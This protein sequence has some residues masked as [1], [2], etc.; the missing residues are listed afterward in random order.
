[1]VDTFDPTAEL[2]AK[3]KTVFDA[4]EM[5]GFAK[6]EYGWFNN[7]N[8]LFVLLEEELLNG[9]P[10]DELFQGVE[11][12]L[13]ENLVHQALTEQGSHINLQDLYDNYRWSE[14]N[15]DENKLAYWV[16][17]FAMDTLLDAWGSDV[18]QPMKMIAK[19]L[20]SLAGKPLY[21]GVFGKRG[22]F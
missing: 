11:L 4:Q 21:T 3:I 19:K 20:C 1:M 14:D 5:T 15:I 17:L 2:A 18:Y 9:A 6:T 16:G 8:N 7:S 10:A 13:A 22:K 12:S